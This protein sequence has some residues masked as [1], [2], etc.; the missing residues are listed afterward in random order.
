MKQRKEVVQRP[1]GLGNRIRASVL[2]W[3]GQPI[4]LTTTD[5]WSAWAGYPNA[6]GQCVNVTS[7]LALAAFVA[8]IRLIAESISTLP[9]VLYRNTSNGRKPATNHPLYDVLQTLPSP[10]TTASLM[11]ES[12]IASMLMWG[13]GRAQKLV[14]NDRV[15]GLEFLDPLRL[16]V[17]CN[18]DGT[19]TYKYRERNGSTRTLS[20]KEIFGVP[21]FSLDGY[22][23]LSAI[24]Y[25]A[26]VLGTAMA[27]DNAA[28]STFRNGLMPTTYFSVDRILKK[29]QRDEFRDNTV[30]KITGAMNA[31]KPPLLE[32]GMKVGT[33]GINPTDAQLLESRGWSVEEI[34][35]IMRVPP[36]MIGHTPEG[37]TK[38]GTGMEQELLAFLTFSLR[39][40]LTRIEQGIMKDLL[41]PSERVSYFAKY[42]LTDFLR[43]DT[44]AR[45][46][47]YTAMTSNGV[48]T[49]DEC[50][51]YENLPLMGGNASK[52]T[53]QSAMV[54]LD[55]LGKIKAPAPP[56][57]P[58]SAL[59][60]HYFGVRSNET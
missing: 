22:N 40:W 29:D 51:G 3:L 25:G 26:N 24:Q 42:D 47:F 49:R 9:I 41:S 21:G 16:N 6:S 35:R 34:C 8:C 44:A 19:Y 32:M 33:V 12:Y 15:V 45:S 23:G 59:A 7:A 10:D 1:R 27:A 5:F 55:D 53:V 56:P 39:P 2:G 13:W 58:L 57:D 30:G 54:L 46:A 4:G 43:A 38:W 31:G 11:W 52:L 17:T 48:M 36:W 60:A 50:R 14:F 37:S 18:P 20:Q 28:G